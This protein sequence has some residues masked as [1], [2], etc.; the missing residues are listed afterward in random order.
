VTVSSGARSQP[1]RRLYVSR[2]AG[3]D[4]AAV[5]HRSSLAAGS[6]FEGPAIVEQMDSTTYVPPQF[7]CSQDG[8]GN[9]ILVRSPNAS[10]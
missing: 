5:Y 3:F 9:L 2:S 10:G 1:R 4:D 8:H 6:T 7:R